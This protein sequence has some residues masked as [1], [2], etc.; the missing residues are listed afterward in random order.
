MQTDDRV[1]AA[2]GFFQPMP[3][4]RL[5]RAGQVGTNGGRLDVD[6]TGDDAEPIGDT[7]AERYGA[8]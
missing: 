5:L 8:P 4:V 1:H 6:E 7:E 2:T 3:D